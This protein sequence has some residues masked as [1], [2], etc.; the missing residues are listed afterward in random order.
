MLAAEEEDQDESIDPSAAADALNDFV[1]PT[2]EKND[3]VKDEEGGG[4][5]GEEEAGGPKLEEESP[6]EIRTI[7]FFLVGFH[8]EIWRQAEKYSDIC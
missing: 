5:G 3:Q 4:L 7:S 6:Q 2:A 1:G 8:N